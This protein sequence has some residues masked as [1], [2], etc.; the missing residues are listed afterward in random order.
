VQFLAELFPFSVCVCGTRSKN[1]Q[2]LKRVS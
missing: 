1:Y 2:T